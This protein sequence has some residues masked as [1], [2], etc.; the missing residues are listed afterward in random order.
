MVPFEVTSTEYIIFCL[1]YK[2]ISYYLL[3]DE[4]PPI[5]FSQVFCR[6]N[7]GTLM[8]SPDREKAPGAY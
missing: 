2:V 7:T 1:N 8:G 3:R 4:W 6:V 5:Y